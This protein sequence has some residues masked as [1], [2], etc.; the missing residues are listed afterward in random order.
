M[1]D[2]T[3]VLSGVAQRDAIV[4]SEKFSA[5]GVECGESGRKLWADVVAFNGHSAQLGTVRKGDFLRAVVSPQSHKDAKGNWRVRFVVKQLLPGEQLPLP[6]L[7]HIDAEM[8]EQAPA[9]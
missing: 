9:S 5:V 2:N 1:H 4:P 3:M 8:R 6:E 7:A